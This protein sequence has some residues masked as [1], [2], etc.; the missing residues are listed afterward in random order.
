MLLPGWKLPGW[1]VI[2][3]AS[4]MAGMTTHWARSDR[5]WLNAMA[6]IA[7]LV[8]ITFTGLVVNSAY[9]ALEED[10]L[11]EFD[12]KATGLTE[13]VE[14][15]ISDQQHL[16]LG[17]R[18]LF[19]G[20]ADVSRLDF[21][22]Y[23][24]SIDL[25]SSFPGAFAM[26]WFLRVPHHMLKDFER[27]VREDQ[28]IDPEGYPDF[29]VY[30]ESDADEHHVVT[31][32]Y[33]G[34][35]G[36][37]SFGFDLGSNHERLLTLEK[38]RDSGTFAATAPLKLKAQ[39]VEEQGF[40]LMLPVYS[41][42]RPEN[43]QQRRQ[44]YIGMLSGVFNIG[45]LMADSR[46]NEFTSVAI[47]DVTDVTAEGVTRPRIMAEIAPFYT[48]GTQSDSPTTLYKTTS[49]G[50]R[51]WEFEITMNP[52][53]MQSLADNSLSWIIGVLG[54]FFSILASVAAAN[55]SAARN[56]ALRQAES[57]S[58]ELLQA[59]SDLERSNNDLSQ[60]AYIASH[61]LQTPVRNV[62]MSVTLLEDALTDR[63]DPQVREYLNYL[64]ESSGRMR[65]LVEDLLE[66]ARVDRET[67]QLVELD[68][69]DIVANVERRLALSMQEVDATLVVG[70][71]PMVQGDQDQ[72]ER[73]FIN[74]L[75][76]A[77]KYKHE[78]RPPQISVDACLVGSDW[79]VRISDNGMGIDKRF[80]EKVF[81]PFQRLHTHAAVG[82]TGL[83]LG[84]CKQIVACHDGDIYI[85]SSSD[86]GTTFVLRLPAH[87]AIL[88]QAA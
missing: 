69:N 67:L 35:E 28:S 19:D 77:M 43:L 87:E 25:A 42:T 10:R 53:A 32:R 39:A 44:S 48:V 22:R 36:R 75:T 54:A 11:V 76:N 59:N 41:I 49:V 83:G 46:Q 85:E 17:I 73:L 62:D 64:R 38:A 31:Y 88:K 40:L 2:C 66:F 3:V 13:E 8:G 1:C 82:G 45:V 30:P 23:L 29:K 80:Y 51:D 84:I 81:E 78:D 21:K 24:D 71:L 16:M 65:K 60:F 33:P 15:S 37:S 9:Q 20:S 55:L 34:F 47:R 74:L 12:R 5:G 63:M 26:A 70:D 27:I 4:F 86:A 7:F 52:A 56:R 6:V 14:N 72:L 50:G 61:D 79:E 57:L 18:S 58:I 68:L